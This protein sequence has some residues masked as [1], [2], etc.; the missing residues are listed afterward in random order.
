MARQ[1]FDL[2]VSW[3]HPQRT[4]QPGNL[5]SAVTGHLRLAGFQDLAGKKSGRP[6]SV[7]D[8]KRLGK[9]QGS[10]HQLS[11]LWVK[12]Q[13]SEQFSGG[14]GYRAA[15]DR[16]TGS[17]DLEVIGPVAGWTSGQIRTVRA[18]DPHY[19]KR[20]LKGLPQRDGIHPSRETK[21]PRANNLV[22]DE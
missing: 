7:E 12:V 20:S 14:C 8:A 1:C 6:E 10:K 4:R 3:S 2:S 5:T 16:L 22:H 18:L 13:W 19:I 9:L 21:E 17:P 11:F 15:G